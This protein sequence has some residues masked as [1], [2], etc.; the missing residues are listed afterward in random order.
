MPKRCEQIFSQFYAI[1]FIQYM[2]RLTKLGMS[3]ACPLG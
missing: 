1:R 2:V 3:W